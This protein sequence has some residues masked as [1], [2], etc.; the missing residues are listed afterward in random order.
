M[1]NAKGINLILSSANSLGKSASKKIA[2]ALGVFSALWLSVVPSTGFAD[3]LPM[4]FHVSSMG[5]HTL[6]EKRVI[7]SHVPAL[8]PVQVIIRDSSK[9]NPLFPFLYGKTVYTIASD[10]VIDEGQSGQ[11]TQYKTHLLDFSGFKIPGDYQ[12][13]LQ[14][15]PVKASHLKINDFVYWDILKPVIKT[16]YF[17]R[18]GQL[19]QDAV[20]DVSHSP[21]HI[22][23]AIL[24]DDSASF[25]TK[26]ETELDVTGGWHDGKNYN[27]TTASTVL[28][29]AQLLSLAQWNPSPLKYFRLN[30]P[31][32]EPNYGDFT[33]FYHEVKAGLD[34]LLSMQKNNGSVYRGVKALHQGSSS[35]L[36]DLD[37]GVRIIGDVSVEDTAGT[38][39]TMA[40]A[41]RNFRKT[42]ESYGVKCLLAAEKAWQ[43]LALLSRANSS[44]QPVPET[45][46]SEETPEEKGMNSKLAAYQT[47]AAAELYISTGKPVYHQYLLSHWQTL[48]IQPVSL[49]NPALLGLIHYILY[50]P[51][52]D[53][54]QKRQMTTAI[55]KLAK[56][57]THTI[58]QDPHAAGLKQFGEASNRQV[59]EQINTLLM[60]YRLTK[61]EDYRQIASR[62]LPYLF[63]L[64]PL[65]MTYMTGLPGQSVQHLS[66]PWMVASGKPLLGF[67]AD[68]PN[69][70][71][72]DRFTPVNPTAA[73]CYTDHDKA[74]DSN[75]SSLLNNASVAMALALLNH[76]FN[77]I[78]SQTTTPKTASPL[79][80]QLAPD[81]G[82]KKYP[83][84]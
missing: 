70:L 40:I 61:N 68:G 35:V 74:T 58:Q 76:A 26:E 27:K 73:R 67:L 77:P 15:T 30:Y 44:S 59:T 3:E 52:P 49:N 51:N 66:N 54:T 50:A 57:I 42:G 31:L 21:C 72:N 46:S 33:D 25:A 82:L 43:S 29:T 83:K 69:R 6:G 79:D 56:R 53:L 8:Q 11:G 2:V 47:W 34:W 75:S 18:C 10:T 4:T 63:G 84:K 45:G 36:P 13:E 23:D 81:R 39:A 41:A 65:G 17:Q 32:D 5:Y 60:A 78:D 16:F 14:G 64:N 1:T 20:L 37:D 12:I 24:Q 7:L 9:R 38:A 22:K 19:V 62:S 55:D 80:Y 48:T 71:A 28:A